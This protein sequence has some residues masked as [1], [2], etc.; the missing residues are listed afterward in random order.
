MVPKNPRAAQ[1]H[2]A[3]TT[4]R[5]EILRSIAERLAPDS[6]YFFGMLQHFTPDL[7]ATIWFEKGRPSR[8]QTV[9]YLKRCVRSIDPNSESELK[10][11]FNRAPYATVHYSLTKTSGASDPYEKARWLLKN[12]ARG[13]NAKQ[14]RGKLCPGEMHPKAIVIA[15]VLALLEHLGKEKTASRDVT[16]LAAALYQ[17]I[18]PH[19]RTWRETP[20]HSWR[21]H[22]ASA[23]SEIENGKLTGQYRLWL[24][25]FN[26]TKSR[27]R[28]PFSV[29]DF[30]NLISP[31]VGDVQA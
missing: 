1:Y 13:E 19:E 8:S 2:C 9:E 21:K 24:T 16:D 31:K 12:W 22:L 17:A 26:Q 28:T 11:Y 23:K 10:A 7:S 20:Y 4:P 29:H 14:G 27:G 25:L 5:T 15:F 30:D 18:A 6:R 3:P